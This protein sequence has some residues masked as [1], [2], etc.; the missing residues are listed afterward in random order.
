M[1]STF[2]S[3]SSRKLIVSLNERL[4]RDVDSTVSD[5]FAGCEGADSGLTRFVRLVESV[6]QPNALMAQI[7]QVPLCGKLLASLISL[8]PQLADVL[9]QNPELA[10]TILSPDLLMEALDLEQILSDGRT[11]IQHTSSYTHQLDRLRFLKQKYILRIA[12]LDLGDMVSQPEIWRRISVLAQAILTLANEVA[13]NQFCSRFNVEGECPVYVLCMGKFGG[14]ELNYSSD[15]DL[16]FVARDDVGPESESKL[17]KFAELLRA[18]LADRMGRG[19]LYR[20]DLRLRPFGSQGP[21][22]TK[23][24]ALESYYQRFSEPWEHLAMIRSEFVGADAEYRKRWEDIRS[25]IVFGKPRGVWVLENLVS[26]RKR[27]EDQG[28]QMDLKKGAGG[29]RDVEF[30][31]Q[32][33]QML[34]GSQHSSLKGSGTLLML[35]KLQEL[36]LIPQEAA[37]DLAGSYEFL[38]KLEHRCQI[39]DGLQTHKLPV[40]AELLTRVAGSMGFESVLALQTELSFHRQRIRRWYEEA[41]SGLIGKSMPEPHESWLNSLEGGDRFLRSLEVNQGSRARVDKVLNI[42]PALI[43]VLKKSV[44]LSEQIIS[45]EIE[46]AFDPEALIS[47]LNSRS[48]PEEISQVMQSTWARTCL[49]WQLSDGLNLG[50]LL[51]RN[52]DSFLRATLLKIEGISS[53][54]TLGSYAAGEL[55][56]ASDADIVAICDEDADR[57]VVERELTQ[58]GSVLSKARVMGS[59]LTL[60]FRL[61]PEGRSGR[62]AVT[63]SQLRKYEI[64]AMELWERFALVRSRVIGESEELRSF[65][66]DATL[67]E[68]LDDSG[69]NELLKMK[70]R[71]ENERISPKVKAR[72]IKLGNG[73]LDDVVWLVQLWM[74]RHPFSQEGEIDCGTQARIQSLVRSQL[75]SVVEGEE[76]IEGYQFLLDLRA[77]MFFLGIGDDVMPENPDK[78][79]RV[80]EVSGFSEPNDLLAEYTSTT[81]RLRDYFENGI[82]RMKA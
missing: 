64:E 78:L 56:P 24:S 21:M 14:R 51:Q 8:S 47:R 9:A 18:C 70:K 50:R 26:V 59:P 30:L 35:E 25:Q 28:G 77:R 20:V 69:L 74:M 10:E 67:S 46:E 72:H 4:G 13:W 66:F 31:V 57:S 2:E 27:A 63:L 34:L 79:K 60:D 44:S 40:D 43:P 55:S 7:E 75:I 3:D 82:E 23:M 36:K 38:R 29:I 80:A 41:F 76:L 17:P 37:Q 42:S 54:I 52:L 6:S 33:L 32:T 68:P 11:M 12:V 15:I 49:R 39:I 45:G 53:V 73:G 62:L 22:I 58:F 65:V 5:M 48:K 71:I 81:R 19:E 16:I 1:S 61:R